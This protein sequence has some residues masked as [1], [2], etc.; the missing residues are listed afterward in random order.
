[1]ATLWR[2]IEGVTYI[3]RGNPY[4]MQYER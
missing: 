4:T 3:T 1:M 2:A